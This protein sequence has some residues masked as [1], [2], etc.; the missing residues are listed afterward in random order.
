MLK[1]NKDCH[2]KENITIDI[3]TNGLGVDNRDFS[4]IMKLWDKI[5]GNSFYEA[6]TD[7]KFY[8]CDGET[9]DNIKS[10]YSMNNKYNSYKDL[11]K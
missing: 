5:K 9:F 8:Y 10:I 4:D 6:Y 1:I 7:N 11:W 3:E 2:V